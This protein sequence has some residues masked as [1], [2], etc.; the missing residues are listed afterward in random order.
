MNNVAPNEVRSLL[1]E[2][3]IE[4]HFVELYNHIINAA[5]RAIQIF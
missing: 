1:E 5:E 4:L 2:E 3:K